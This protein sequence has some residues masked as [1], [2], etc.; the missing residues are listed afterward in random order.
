MFCPEGS[1]VPQLCPA[2]R[3]NPS[4]NMDSIDDCI[5]CPPGK[6]C[7]TDG[8]TAVAGDCAAGYYCQIGGKEITP[9][10]DENVAE[11]C[12]SYFI[13]GD[14]SS[15]CIGATGPRIVGPCPFGH[16]CDEGTAY[17][18]PC[19]IGTYRDALRGENSGACTD[20]DAGY[21]G[22]ETGLTVSTCSGQCLP[23][24]YCTGGEITHSPNG[25]HCTAGNYCPQGSI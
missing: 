7:D 1:N 15:A 16:Y 17:P 23:G 13:D 9:Q 20:C 21:Y 22:K 6:Y 8:G 18:V 11:V 25:Q 10:S 3:F 14:T 2:G 5:P 19:P 4:R 24:F 12:D